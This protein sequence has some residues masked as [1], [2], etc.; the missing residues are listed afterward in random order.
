MKRRA[1]TL[2]TTT[3]AAATIAFAMTGGVLADVCFWSGQATDDLFSN[4]L[5]WFPDP[6]PVAGDS[7]AFISADLTT[8]DFDF[9]PINVN[10]T[11]DGAGAL[12]RSADDGLGMRHYMLNG[13]IDVGG[14]GLELRGLDLTTSHWLV[15]DDGAELTVLPD[16]ER[17]CPG[18]TL[19]VS[20]LLTIGDEAAGT[21]HVDG[22]TVHSGGSVIGLD[23]GAFGTMIVENAVWNATSSGGDLAVG[24]HG[25]GTLTVTGSST[26]WSTHAELGVWSDSQGH[27]VVEGDGALWAN[28]G[29]LSVGGRGPA[30]LEINDGAT[31]LS[32]YGFVGSGYGGDGVVT[33]DG[34]SSRWIGTGDLA[35]G[36][37]GSGSVSL[38]GGAHASN[39]DA[40]IGKYAASAGALSVRDPRTRWSCAGDL[41]VG[42]GGDGL[43][44]IANGATV[45]NVDARIGS[46]PGGDGTVV[47]NGPGSNWASSGA[48]FVGGWS[49]G[50][51]GDGRL[52]I[53]QGG[54][55]EIDG[56]MRIWGDGAVILESGWLS[57]DSIERTDHGLFQ[58]TGGTLLLNSF[59][60]D[61]IN[62]GGTLRLGGVDPSTYWGRVVVLGDYIQGAGTLELAIYGDGPDEFE[63]LEAFDSAVVGGWLKVH[64]LP[65]FVP[66]PD[67]AFPIVTAESLDG[68]FANA[69]S[70]VNVHGGGRFRVDYLYDALVPSVTLT[71]YVSS[72]CPG[73]VNGS[74][75]T[76]IIDL[77][78][79]LSSWGPCDDCPGDIDGSGDVGF[80]DLLAVLNSWG[81]C[82]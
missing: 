53:T 19:T 21:V 58:F 74:G 63:A 66:D 22:G 1:T 37:F 17:D 70:F 26:V 3:A 51:G 47:V 48:V 34:P 75:T 44:V 42:R 71:D 82:P 50:S 78:T 43:M 23:P 81:P 14:G 64:L 57:V 59:D 72:E 80:A 55:V 52:E 39:V 40:Y 11:I 28:I 6:V 73:D 77:V 60:G 9:D 54:A 7:V 20:S 5:N 46:E 45:T 13:F 38:C 30:E 68:V 8:V 16:P 29:T 32:S 35:V 62:S 67:D 61:L 12:F 69:L 49:R 24:W 65:G 33:I 36:Y 25:I 10:M 4:P 79:V 76:G 56:W 15:V 41:W 2:T 18:S 31:V 27:A